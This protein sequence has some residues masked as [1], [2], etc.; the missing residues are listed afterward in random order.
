MKISLILVVL[1]S[2][3]QAN[4]HIQIPNSQKENN[5]RT[6]GTADGGGVDLNWLENGE[7]WFT[8]AIK[9]SPETIKVCFEVNSDHSPLRKQDLI[10]S[11]QKSFALWKNYI[12]TYI[13]KKY[14]Q[15]DFI[16][17]T[18]IQSAC[19]DNTNLYVYHGKTNKFTKKHL[20]NTSIPPLAYAKL[21]RSQSKKEDA[22][23]FIYISDWADFSDDI[24][25][26]KLK[27]QILLNHE[28]GHSFGTGH[29]SGTIMDKRIGLVLLLPNQN[30]FL[31]FLQNKVELG[32]LLSIDLY[33]LDTKSYSFPGKLIR[34]IDFKCSKLL[35]SIIA[36]PI[37]DCENVKTTF[38]SPR[39][40]FPNTLSNE[41]DRKLIIEYKNKEYR[42]SVVLDKN[43]IIS[44]N[45][46]DGN[47]F[48]FK[49][50]YLDEEGDRV[51][52]GA[53]PPKARNILGT[54]KQ[55]F[56]EKKTF[57]ILASINNSMI[58]LQS[59]PNTADKNLVYTSP[60]HIQLIT[61]DSSIPLFY[62]YEELPPN[63]DIGF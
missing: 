27:L 54:L 59:D 11:F 12:N 10:D 43:F 61:K 13:K 56:G 62:N 19:D 5:F 41:K 22:Y 28:L 47:I 44:S 2:Y 49:R 52:L 1:L 23:G 33:S 39:N 17:E 63:I 36:M 51:S 35:E 50:S 18:E 30:S 34:D 8:N 32:S 9:P 60:F 40:L 7:A 42:F 20:P 15:V 14:D 55:E 38:E 21:I 57:K 25:S 24:H 53:M 31:S 26:A 16:L 4:S 46:S 37:K 58:R 3:L 45:H 29:I 48:V 6:F